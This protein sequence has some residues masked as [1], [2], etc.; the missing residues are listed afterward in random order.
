MK[1]CYNYLAINFDENLKFKDCIKSRS[2]AT[3]TAYP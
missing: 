3:F 1:K 2:D